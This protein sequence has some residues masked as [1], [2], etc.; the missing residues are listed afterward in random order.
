VGKFSKVLLENIVRVLFEAKQLKRKHK[1]SFFY[2]YSMAISI[3]GC[4]LPFGGF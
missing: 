4:F 2:I 3:I 1:L